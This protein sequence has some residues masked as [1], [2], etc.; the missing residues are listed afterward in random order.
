M[1][2][3]KGSMVHAL[4]RQGGI[5]RART[6]TPEERRAS[7]KKAA[8]ARWG[9]YREERGTVVAECVADGVGVV[10]MEAFKDVMEGFTAPRKSDMPLR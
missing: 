6:H 3:K 1:P 5:A 7:A 4:A 8:N 9:R 10:E 2:E